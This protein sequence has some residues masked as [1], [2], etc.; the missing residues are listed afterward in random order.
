MDTPNYGIGTKLSYGVGSVAFGVKD[1]GFGSLLLLFYNQALGLDARLAAL[2]IAI[3]L[4]VD[5]LIDPL[6]GHASDNLDT[7]WGRR[8][9]FM[10]A[11]AV[12]AA[13]SY[14]FLFSPPTGLG[15]TGLFVY[16][17]VCGVLVRACIALFEIPNSALIAELTQ[18]YEERTSYLNWRLFFGW[19]AG[20]TMSVA[21]FGVFLSQGAA[22]VPGTQVPSN[23]QAYGITAAI[24]MLIGMLASALGTHHTIPRLK[25]STVLDGHL[26]PAGFLKNLNRALSSRSAVMNLLVGLFVM[27]STGLL[28]GITP[29]VYSYLFIL[30]P[31]QVSILY[32][33]AF[34]S[35]FA[36]LA[37][38]PWIS[39]K[40]EK[41]HA[42]IGVTIA[43]VVTT[44]L[45]AALQLMG[46]LPPSDSVVFIPL[47]YTVG[48]VGTTFLIIQSTL[49]Y[50]MSA[51]VIE[52][53]EVRT[54]H[55]QE[56]IFFAANTFVRKCATGL[57]VLLTSAILA[58]VD[59][60]EKA[61]PGSIPEPMI[62]LLVEYFIGSF[63]LLN[64][65][66]IAFVIAYR[67]TRARH[68]EHLAI[69]ADKRGSDIAAI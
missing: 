40:F 53:N 18:N 33:A 28:A 24:L 46:L 13:L 57:G 25:R 47:L 30:K 17:L 61:I 67:I 31:Q 19:V 54:G 44:P 20:L 2:A 1:N 23:Y 22:G 16:L 38:T 60:P 37:S 55:R 62:N 10:Y 45:A 35:A 6:I 51:D 36:A 49:Y 5:A 66:T 41:R 27:L 7:R 43:A 42:Y 29:Y 34:I 68:A 8:H 15:Q 58:F 69:L 3:A 39:R 65:T 4:V 32:S 64:C 50:S 9:P 26:A 12:P 21:A 48:L 52:E 59:F 14:A 11:A 56:G 63:I